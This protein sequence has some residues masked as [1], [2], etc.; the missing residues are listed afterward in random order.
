[1]KQEIAVK[2]KERRKK[3]GL[4]QTQLAKKVG[5]SKMQIINYEQGRGL[6]LSPLMKVAKKLGLKINVKFVVDK[7]KGQV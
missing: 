7:E 2:I 4:T 5:L 3:L 6:G 1:M